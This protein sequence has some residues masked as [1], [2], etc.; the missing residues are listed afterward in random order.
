MHETSRSFAGASAAGQ[1][2]R[3][4]IRG[5]VL[6]PGQDGYDRARQIWNA[7]IDKRPRFIARCSGPADVQAAVRIGRAHG[8]PMS[9]RGGGHNIAGLSLCDDGL[10]IDL[11][12]MKGIVVDPAARTA[13]A[14]AGLTWGEFDA[15]TQRDGLATTGGAVSTTGIAGL[16]L[17]GG[18]GWLMGRCGFTVDNLLSA[19][20]VLNDGTLIE[21]SA[22][23][24]PDLFWAL[25]GGGGNF[26]VVTSFTYRLHDV[27]PV[28]AGV[29]AHPIEDLPDMLRFYRAFVSTAPDELTAHAGTMTLPGAGP[30]AIMAMVWS[31]DV[32]EG[33][34]RLAPLRG[35][36]RPLADMVQVMP[37]VSAQQL[38]DAAAP[39]GRHNYWKSGFV[40]DIPDDVARLVGDSARTATSP[41]SICL[42]E[43]V[44]GAATRVPVDATAFTMRDE[45]FHFI[46]IASWDGSEPPDPHVRWARDLWSSMQR[47]ATGEVYMNI[48]GED[49]G[50]RIA[51]AYGQA[52]GRL[53]AVKARYDAE[54]VF[55]RNQNIVPA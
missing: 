31:G 39:S 25:R 27:G 2:L 32:S 3:D 20:V 10:V 49:E 55:T 30:A 42:I 22:T 53:A 4:Q 7:M 12:P 9:V 35:F 18:L 8:L 15:A 51:A 11:S 1:A 28:L 19:R 13:V 43:H 5:T 33:E 36:G 38:L 41:F 50:D 34:R 48:L 40:R 17:G 16:T 54:N 23:E 44:H 47:W 45:H 29:I 24:H 21:A 37:Y 52:Y 14:D 46:A 6:E 26:G